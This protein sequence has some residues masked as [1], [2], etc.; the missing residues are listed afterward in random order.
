MIPL[1]QVNTFCAHGC[2]TGWCERFTAQVG[3]RSAPLSLS[4]PVGVLGSV[5]GQYSL[6]GSI[7]YF[8]PLISLWIHTHTAY[9]LTQYTPAAPPTIHLHTCTTW[10]SGASR[11]YH[12]PKTYWFLTRT[13]LRWLRFTRSLINVVACIGIEPFRAVKRKSIP[14]EGDNS[15]N[16]RDII[17]RF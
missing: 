13:S 9:A 12:A 17:G 7:T 2:V 11:R 8:Y 10:C 15:N 14:A 16:G 4:H 3:G 1:W 5:R 6:N